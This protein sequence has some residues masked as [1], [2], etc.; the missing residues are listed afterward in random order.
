MQQKNRLSVNR[1]AGPALLTLLFFGS[2][3]GQS[4]N[5]IGAQTEGIRG[6]E[7]DAAMLASSGF[8]LYVSVREPSGLPVTENATVK[9]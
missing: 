1:I 8:K 2:A 6:S 7:I 5:P 3:A 9:L 4:T